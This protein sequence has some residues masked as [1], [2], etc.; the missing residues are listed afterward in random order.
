MPDRLIVMLR[1]TYSLIKGHSN[2]QCMAPLAEW[3]RDTGEGGGSR[4]CWY[5]ASQD[6]GIIIRIEEVSSTTHHIV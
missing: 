2:C 1:S 5:W 6:K 4:R 3:D